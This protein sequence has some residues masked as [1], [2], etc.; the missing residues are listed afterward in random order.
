MPPFPVITELDAERIRQLGRG[1]PDR[2]RGFTALDALLDIADAAEIVPGER[3]PADVVTVNSTVS[4]REVGGD[5]VLRVTIVYPAE[6]SVADR[7]ISIL[8]P[9]GRALLGRRVGDRVSLDMPDG[10]VRRI[11]VVALHYQP[12]AAGHFT[13]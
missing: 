8:S 2:G 13:R 7:R 3:V 6:F 4:F 11:E 12:E 5:A 10:S 1:L 9:V